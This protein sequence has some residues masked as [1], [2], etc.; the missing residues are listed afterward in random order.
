M[1][2]KYTK[3][4]LRDMAQR[5]IQARGEGDV[6]YLQFV[7]A[8]SMKTGYSPNFVKRNIEIMARG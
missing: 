4:Q 2:D 3:D 5:V 6:R 7:M 1:D 8:L